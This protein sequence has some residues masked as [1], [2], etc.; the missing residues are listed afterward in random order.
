MK[1]SEDGTTSSGSVRATPLRF[2]RGLTGVE[3]LGPGA[4]GSGSDSRQ[5]AR[6][7]CDLVATPRPHLSRSGGRGHR[8][9]SWRDSASVSACT[10]VRSSCEAQDAGESSQLR[11][12]PAFAP[13]SLPL[14]ISTCS[15]SVPLPYTL[16]QPDFSLHFKADAERVLFYVFGGRGSK[17]A[18]RYNLNCDAARKALGPRLCPGKRVLLTGKFQ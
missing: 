5:A 8:S 13:P 6:R 9:W 4:T 11:K 16:P 1:R 7:S 17:T 10:V 14:C 15:L 18:R 2:S 12:I 3:V